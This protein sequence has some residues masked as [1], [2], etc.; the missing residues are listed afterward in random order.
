MTKKAV[1]IAYIYTDISTFNFFCQNLPHDA[2]KLL[3]VPSPIGGVLVISANAIHYHSQVNR[4]NEESD[5]LILT[6]V[7][8]DIFLLYAVNFMCFGFEQLCCF[9]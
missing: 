4:V 6:T 8:M 2:Y 7:L 9:C 1:S 3:A 5:L